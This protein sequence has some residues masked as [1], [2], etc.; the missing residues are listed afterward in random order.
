VFG[1]TTYRL[2]KPVSGLLLLARSTQA[3]GRMRK[4]LEVGNVLVVD[5][6]LGGTIQENAA[7]R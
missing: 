3:A 2:D 1:A 7:S 4:L 6:Q 5:T